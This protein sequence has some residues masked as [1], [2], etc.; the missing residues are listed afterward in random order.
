M[1]E[2]DY[3]YLVYFYNRWSGKNVKLTD[4]KRSVVEKASEHYDI[5]DM[6]KAIIGCFKFDTY[7]A[8]KY[9]TFEYIFRLSATNNNIKRFKAMYREA[10]DEQVVEERAVKMEKI[11][12]IRKGMEYGTIDY[13]D[14]ELEHEANELVEMYEFY[15]EVYYPSRKN[16]LEKVKAALKE[17]NPIYIRRAINYYWLKNWSNKKDTSMEKVVNIKRVGDKIVMDT[18]FNI[19]RKMNVPDLIMP[20]SVVGRMYKQKMRKDRWVL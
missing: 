13:T 18:I 19:N 11:L 10:D 8:R 3:K 9:K 5:E 20:I 4:S 2:E 1:N 15:F 7:V 17:Y 6:K 12:T 16:I 14:E